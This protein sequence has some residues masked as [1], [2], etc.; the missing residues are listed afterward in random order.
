MFDQDHDRPQ[1]TLHYFETT[2]GSDRYQ[3]VEF[4]LCDINL[5]PMRRFSCVIPRIGGC[6]FVTKA[7][8]KE[9]VITAVAMRN[10]E[11]NKII[12]LRIYE[13]DYDDLS[14]NMNEIEWYRWNRKNE[15]PQAF[16][17][18]EIRQRNKLFCTEVRLDGAPAGR[19]SV[20]LFPTTVVDDVLY[21]D[22][23]RLTATFEERGKTFGWYGD[24][25]LLFVDPEHEKV[26]S[27]FEK[28]TTVRSVRIPR[29]MRSHS[30]LNRMVDYLESI[31][32]RTWGC[33]PIE[34]TMS[35][36]TGHISDWL[37]KRAP[38]LQLGSGQSNSIVSTAVGMLYQYHGTSD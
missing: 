24:E 5:V 17:P 6:V 38:L 33:P 20:P 27:T 11:L 10:F 36:C 25:F 3:E 19:P 4:A 31:R 34:M 1:P 14:T 28:F 16:I 37:Y 21:C 7:K 35:E 18:R 15:I 9:A 12:S 30:T 13:I 23:I 22:R 32:P 2:A 8:P 26:K 29:G